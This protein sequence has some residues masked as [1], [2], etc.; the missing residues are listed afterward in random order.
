[1]RPLD[2]K[3]CRDLWRLRSQVFTIALVVASGVGGFLGPLSAHDSLVRLRDGYYETG[4][5]AH[6]FVSAKRAPQRIETA[7]R[8]I[9][10]VVDVQTAIMGNVVISLPG[11]TELMTGRVL[12][13]P[14]YGP[15]A[16]NRL[17]LRSGQWLEPDDPAGVL[18]SDAFARA[19]GLRPGD[20]LMA[21]ING[22]YERL[23]VRGIALS[24]EYIFAVSAGSFSDDSRYAIL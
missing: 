2:R 17:Y 9:S 18:V 14:Q 1:M 8:G 15:P 24:P 16:M 22:K 12:S 19:R 4:R 10:G 20:P 3:L 11:V 23:Q 6:I 7:L 13:V 5:F 21:L